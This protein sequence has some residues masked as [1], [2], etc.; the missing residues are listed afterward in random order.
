MTTSPHTVRRGNGVPSLSRSGAYLLLAFGALLTLAPFYFMFVFAT[1]D[2][3]E[4][5]RLPPPL[6]FGNDAASNYATLIDRVPFW[7][8]LWNSLY[9]AALSTVTTLFFCSLAGFAFAMYTFRGRELLF[10]MVIGT[11]LIPTA[12][13][14]VPFALI[15]QGLGWIDKPRAL[16]VPGMASA[17]GIFM[18][19]QYIGSAIP[20]ELMEAARIDGET[21]FGIYRR[22]IVPLSAPVLGTLGLITFISSWNSFIGPLIIFRS[23]ETQTAPLLLRSL[24]AVANTDWGALMVGVVLTV[25]PLLLVFVFASRQLIDGLTAGSTKG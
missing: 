9:L 13:N 3:T 7:R 25:L 10:S 6:W 1:H 14:I 17:F 16:W 21:E 22:I 11:M 18:T 5:F 20:R 2:R 23:T 19:R 15:M 4:I 8:S 12:L 24:Q